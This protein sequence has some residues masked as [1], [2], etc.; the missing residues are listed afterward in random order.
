MLDNFIYQ[1][2][3]QSTAVIQLVPIVP[4]ALNI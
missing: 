1:I 3:N 4:R 2:T